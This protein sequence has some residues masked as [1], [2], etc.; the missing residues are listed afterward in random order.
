MFNKE[1]FTLIKGKMIN[2]IY[3]GYNGPLLGTVIDCSDQFLIMS[4]KFS[5]KQYINFEQISSF[6]CDDDLPN[7]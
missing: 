6:W 7:E 5:N 4:T 1:I 3:I 2:V